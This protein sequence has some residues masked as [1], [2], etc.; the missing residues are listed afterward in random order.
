MSK[1]SKRA[2]VYRKSAKIVESAVTCLVKTQQ[3][4]TKKENREILSQGREKKQ[5]MLSQSREKK[6]SDRGGARGA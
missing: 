4:T 3:E 2:S 1:D 6:Q 5:R